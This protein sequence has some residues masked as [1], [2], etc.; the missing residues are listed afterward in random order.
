MD[1]RYL[2][3]LLTGGLAILNLG[4]VCLWFAHHARLLRGQ[5]GLLAPKWSLLDVWFGFQLTAISLFILSGLLLSLF[6]PRF[7]SPEQPGSLGAWLQESTGAW[8]LIV[9]IVMLQEGAM[10]GL[11]CALVRW[12]FRESWATIG[13]R[14]FP[15]RREIMQGL[16]AGG[17]MIL[18][19]L[20]VQLALSLISQSLS[21]ESWFRRI[22]REDTSSLA[23]QEL[24]RG[25]EFAPA[26][27]VG[28][29]LF[30][31]I[32]APFC[33]ELLFRG[34]LYNALKKRF[35]HGWAAPV[36]GAIFALVHASVFGFIPRWLIGWLLANMYHRS[37]SL[38]VPFIAHAMNNALALF[39]LLRLS[40]M[41]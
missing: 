18:I 36:S 33:E 35:G 17:I 13:L 22:T 3:F 4:L 6:M 37:G 26:V 9:G 16:I 15:T 29:F 27:I 41:V 40:R 38:W 30:A 21:G 12:R 19:L 14:G 31:V 32:I 5:S 8:V 2:P 23:I 34:V 10:V 25:L 7:D 28:I 24:V 11:S 39:V 1:T 20:L